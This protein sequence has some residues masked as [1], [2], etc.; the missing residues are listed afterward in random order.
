MS[1][2]E[3]ASID[4]RTA[5]VAGAFFQH[6]APVGPHPVA[7]PGPFAPLRHHLSDDFSI[8]GPQRRGIV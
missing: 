3:F 8:D 5:C 2:S 1:T 6:V 7:E 4:S